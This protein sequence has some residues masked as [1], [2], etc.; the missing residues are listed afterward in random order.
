MTAESESVEREVVFP[1]SVDELWD[2][3]T[4]P[5]AVADWFG[6]T[7][8]WEVTPGS[9]FEAHNGE[10]HARRGVIHEVLTHRRLRYRWWPAGDD[11][12]VSEVIYVLEPR[13][14]E[15]LLVVTERRVGPMEACADNTSGDDLTVMNSWRWSV[16][17]TRLVHLWAK[18]QRVTGR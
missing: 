11:Q 12:Q 9:D 16:W 10:G 6:A 17:D 4:D 18:A 1:V 2:A 15:S 7:V 8:T 3:L 5:E 14:P 13:G